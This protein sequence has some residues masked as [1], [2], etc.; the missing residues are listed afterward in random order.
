MR[1]VLYSGGQSR[2]NQ[3]LHRALYELC[4]GETRRPRKRVQLTYVPFCSDDSETYY[5]RIV[6]RYRSY[7][8]TDFHC[9][10]VDRPVK[11]R[12]LV[13]ALRS[14]VIYLAGGNTFYFLKHLKSSGMDQELTKFVRRG[15]VLA[16]LSAGALILTPSIHLAGIP[17]FDADENEVGLKDLRALAL[18]QFEFSPH[19]GASRRRDEA[20]LRYSKRTRHPIFAC[21]DGGGIVV[22]ED[23]LSA[24]GRTFVFY[25]GI[26]YPLLR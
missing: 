1:L 14:D 26:K 9:L 19:Y 11:S 2:E 8:F 24:Y 20:L 13:R 23:I 16:G 21:T 4:L 3:V 7:G 10:P 15:G 22:N 12:D 18:T 6:R 25:R 5:K 17:R